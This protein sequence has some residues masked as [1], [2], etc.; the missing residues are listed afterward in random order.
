M[1]R[2]TRDLDL[3]GFGDPGAERL[4]AV[5]TA[6]CGIDVP[7]DGLTFDADSVRVE[8]IREEQEYGGQRV[9][10]DVSLEQARIDL[11]VDVGFGD[12]IT[13]AAVTVSYPTLLETELPELRAYPKETVVAEKL[14]AM[15]K[16]G[17]ANT[18]MKDF[19]DVLFLARTF[20][21]DGGTLRDAIAATFARRGTSLSEG[22]PV[23]LTDAF[24]QD[25][26]KRKQWAAFAKRS[27][28]PDNLPG[29]DV[30]VAELALFLAE[31]LVAVSSGERFNLSWPPRGPWKAA[32]VEG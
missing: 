6:L 3:L 17:M 25:E 21:F 19:F 29:L 18:R 30:V 27:G 11:Q 12:A 2:P 24:S 5:F 7:A 8:T 16:L 20:A 4:K 31:P 10:L 14:E 26:A 1:H 28:L 32:D 13:P 9:R 23:A 15:V 22:T